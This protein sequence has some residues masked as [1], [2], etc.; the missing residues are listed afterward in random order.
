MSIGETLLSK[1][2]STPTFR[3]STVDTFGDWSIEAGDIIAVDGSSKV[4]IF[5]SDMEWNGTART[6]FSCSGNQKRETQTKQ[7]REQY[8]AGSYG[9]SGVNSLKE[10]TK[11]LFDKFGVSLG[12]VSSALETYVKQTDET[13]L[14]ITETY[15]IAEDV[16]AAL[17]LKAE[18]STVEELDREVK[19]ILSAQAD[20]T[21]R[22]GDAESALAL[23]A[24]QSTVEELDESLKTLYVGQTNLATRVGNAESSL[25]QKVSVTEFD[26]AI[27]AE[28]EAITELSSS[29]DG[30]K[31]SLTLKAEKSTV[32][33]LSSSVATLQ[34]DLIE[35]K[36]DVEVVGNLSVSEGV[37]IVDKSIRTNGNLFVDKIYSTGG[38]NTTSLSIS[39]EYLKL[40]GVA[41]SPTTITSTTGDVTVLGY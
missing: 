3:P 25:L 32:D 39:D 29:V 15:A 36:G 13:L 35:L 4:P 8:S 16:E 37:L 6:T 5:E 11:E 28:Q 23:K 27:A 40:N 18:K 19:T 33:D 17:L 2:Q 1:V 9:F 41:Y 31:A 24:E 30:V 21:T 10:E 34:A 20:L 22:V 14:A 7:E 12:E 38:V 26:E